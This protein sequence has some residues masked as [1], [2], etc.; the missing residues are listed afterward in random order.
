MLA[1]RRRD[2][3]AEVELRSALHRMGLRFRV[4]WPPLKGSRRR[5]DI[6]FTRARVAVFVDGCFWHGCPQH[7][8]QPK[9][10][11]EWWA[12]KLEQNRCR[13]ADTT[14]ALS[15][16]G[17]TVLRF[18]EHEDSSTAAEVVGQAVVS[19]LNQALTTG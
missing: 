10:N 6:V 16:A 5:A 18:W 15:E 11:A 2:T 13:D 3:P 12:E 9:E 17:W 1:T 8:T 7:G 14:R 19:A 4:D